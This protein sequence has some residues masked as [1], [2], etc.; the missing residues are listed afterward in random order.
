MYDIFFERK[1]HAIATHVGCV[2]W[3]EVIFL[4]LFP[5]NAVTKTERKRIRDGKKEK[6]QKQ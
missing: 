2:G 4:L 3:L 5:F 1:K 6:K